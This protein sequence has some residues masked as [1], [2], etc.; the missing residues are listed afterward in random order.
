M[1]IELVETLRCP[2]PHADSWLVASIDTI[3]GR[4]IVS[5]TLGC[6]VCGAKYPVVAGGVEMSGALGGNAA[7]T[8]N[9]AAEVPAVPAVP[10]GYAT[11]VSPSEED[12]GRAAA[13]MSFAGPGRYV[14]AGA[15]GKLVTA[16]EQSGEGTILLL[17]PTPDV[18]ISAAQSVVRA[19]GLVPLAADTF[20]AV[21]LD[22]STAN[23]D[24][25]NGAVRA[26][27]RGG[28][29][30]APASCPVPPGVKVLARD[31]RE[32]VAEKEAIASPAVPLRRA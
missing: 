13:L 27:Q 30:V 7:N 6:P 11:M 2:T 16:L 18:A 10:D 21:L 23:A 20:R 25:A 29:L 31:E 8:P 9:D 19:R 3:E 22:A 12:V 28:R 24:V 32:W 26:L 4:H 1:F 14:L 5:G 15:A 17:S